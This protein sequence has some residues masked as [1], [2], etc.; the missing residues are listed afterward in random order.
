[1]GKGIIDFKVLNKLVAEG[2]GT[3]EIAKHFNVTPGAVS[4]AKTKLKIAVVKDVALESAH[5]VVSKNLDAVAQLQKIN[6]AANKLLDELTGEDRTINRMV[7][8]VEGALSVEGDPKKQGEQIRKVILRVNQ[9]RNTALKACAEIRG[10]LN[11]QLDIFRT[12]YDLQA[13]AEFQ[14]EVLTSIGEEAPDVRDRIIRRLQKGRAIRSA[15]KF[16]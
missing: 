4:Q 14:K 1:V 6:R 11:L 13:I 10:Q 2:K 5:K 7:K 15:I 3:A 9:D 12:L 8:A 16:D